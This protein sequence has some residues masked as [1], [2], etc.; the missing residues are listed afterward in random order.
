MP[1][2]A[3]NTLSLTRKEKITSQHSKIADDGNVGREREGIRHHTGVLIR[4]VERPWGTGN[5]STP[6]G[7]VSVTL[8][9]HSE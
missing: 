3:L 7:K 6:F 9:P 5:A 2:R 8:L 1:S 4:E